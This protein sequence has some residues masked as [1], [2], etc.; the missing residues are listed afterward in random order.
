MNAYRW[1][2]LVIL[3]G[4]TL[5]VIG[6][7]TGHIV[8]FK[9]EKVVLTPEMMDEGFEASKEF[10]KTANDSDFTIAGINLQTSKIDEVVALYGEPQS[11]EDHIWR[12]PDFDIMVH[13]F[14]GT[15]ISVT[16]YRNYR[17]FRGIGIGDS[18]KKVL[19][20]YGK[21]DDF[22]PSRHAVRTQ[23]KNYYEYF[24]SRYPFNIV[25]YTENGK[26]SKMAIEPAM[27]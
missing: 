7:M 4:L 13:E 20:K 25:F 18:V 16:V 24:S 11:K 3:I 21:Y 2:A 17:I 14:Y 26:V 9:P 10:N 1:I 22:P 27:D 19:E 6:F 23:G 15:V 12:Y 5:F 8:V